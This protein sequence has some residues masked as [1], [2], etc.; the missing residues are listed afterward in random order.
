MDKTKNKKKDKQ[1]STKHYTENK[2]LIKINPTITISKF[3]EK[4]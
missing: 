2:R 4:Y 3:G 1:G